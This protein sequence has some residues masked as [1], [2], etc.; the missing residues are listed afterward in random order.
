MK[1]STWWSFWKTATRR[2]LSSWTLLYWFHSPS[3]S[4]YDLS[5]KLHLKLGWYRF[6]S[7]SHTVNNYTLLALRIMH[8]R[9]GP[10]F[11]SF[12]T[13][14]KAVLSRLKSIALINHWFILCKHVS[15]FIIGHFIM[16]IS[17]ISNIFRSMIVISIIFW[18]RIW[19]Y[20]RLLN[21][22]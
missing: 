17:R 22:K 1:F 11:K 10:T 4:Q 7:H 21:L 16:L 15:R 6:N 14:R 18:L 3:L 9:C 2:N 13:E 8:K 12:E 5:C 19:N 20:N